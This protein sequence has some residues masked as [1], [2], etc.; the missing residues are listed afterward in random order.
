MA[1][2]FVFN[3]TFNVLYPDFPGFIEVPSS[4]RLL[5]KPGHQ[6]IV[7][8][9]Y[10]NVSSFYQAA[11]KP[12]S[13]V[14]ISW[15]N[16]TGKGRFF[17]QILSTNPSKTFGQNKPTL[18]KAIGTGLSL[19]QNEPKIWSNKRASE[20][21]Q[22]IAN[23]FKL[24]PIVVPTKPILTQESMVGQ[25][26]WQKLRELADK[27]GYIFHVYETE[28]Y[29]L[30]FD[31][32]INKFMGSIPVLSLTTNYGNGYDDI[33]MSTL[34]EFNSESQVIPPHMRHSNRTKN[35]VG[36]DPLTGKYFSGTKSPSKTGK[37]LRLQRDAQSFSEHLYSTTVGSKVVAEARAKAAAE[38]SRFNE[39]ARGQAQG[40]P[41]IAPYK[42]IQINGTGSYTDGFWI[43]KTADHYMTH[44]GRYLVDFTCM[45]DGSGNNNKSSFRTTPRADVSTRNVAY[46][47]ASGLQKSPSVTL[48]SSKKTLIQ[49]TDS[50]LE[51]KQR[52]WVG[53]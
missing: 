2:Q 36:I 7:E 9:E 18:V 40:D 25:T 43:V 35:V 10:F 6:D 21:A 5:Q 15:S 33:S 22:E 24:K 27:S 8:I 16:G 50:G 47:L 31:T 26:Y 11:L 45:T 46:E 30:P 42:I 23:K 51:F 12:G 29:F 48:L 39:L 37:G 3:N 44:D 19:K 28:L 32:M 52:R 13:L 17:G 1:R 53:R 20:I 38:L 14:K 34:L 41:R 49:Q 4:V